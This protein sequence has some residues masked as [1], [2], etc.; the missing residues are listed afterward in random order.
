MVEI[1]GGRVNWVYRHFPLPFHNPVAQK[2]AEA[3]ECV[4]ELGGNEAFWY[5]T[6]ALYA[7]GPIGDLN[8]SMVDKM[9]LVEELDLDAAEF[10]ECL[11][12]ERYKARVEEDLRE[13]SQIGI[14]GTPGTVVLNNKSG[15]VRLVVGAQPT[16]VLAAAIEQIIN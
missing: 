1:Y 3:S 6:D 16:K 12:S 4:T 2:A 11:D 7:R 9:T 8:Q 13:G 5:F 14:N 10:I 15:E